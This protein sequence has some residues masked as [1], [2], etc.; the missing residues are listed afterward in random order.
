MKHF[1]WFFFLSFE[2]CFQKLSEKKIINYKLDDNT[3][4]WSAS[5][6]PMGPVI[7]QKCPEGKGPTLPPPLRGEFIFRMNCASREGKAFF[8]ALLCTQLVFPA[9]GFG[10]FLFIPFA[11]GMVRVCLRLFGPESLCHSWREGGVVDGGFK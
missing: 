7:D 9:R 2:I 5:R 4:T 8:S 6:K 10:A 11:E 1:F 3:E